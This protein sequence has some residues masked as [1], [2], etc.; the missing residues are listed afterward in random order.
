MEQEEQEGAGTVGMAVIRQPRERMDLVV[1][2]E[3]NRA[4]QEVTAEM[5]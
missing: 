1:E 5:A 2:V 4:L 3:E